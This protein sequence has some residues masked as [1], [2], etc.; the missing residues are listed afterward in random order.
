MQISPAAIFS[1][2][3]LR[4]KANWQIAC[5]NITDIVKKEYRIDENDN[6]YK[7]HLKT[8]FCQVTSANG[9]NIVQMEQ[10]WKSATI[11]Y[12]TN[13]SEP[14]SQSKAY[15][16][17]FELPKTNNGVTEIRF[18]LFQGTEKISNTQEKSI[19]LNDALGKKYK[20]LL[21]TAQKNSNSETALTNGKLGSIENNQEW[22][23]FKNGDMEMVIDFEK[24]RNFRQINV[25]FTERQQEKVFLPEYVLISASID[26]KN[27]LD[28]NRYDFLPLPK[29]SANIIQTA[30][31]PYSEYTSPKRFLK[32]TAKISQKNTFMWADEVTVR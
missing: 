25:N 16:A 6:D 19:A 11:H 32:I 8:I 4:Q 20:L 18:A 9:K 31:L 1:P 17:P 27:W 30:E 7:E 13:G 23:V 15:T 10:V 2:I 14:T 3:P 26:G 29:G 21:P 5:G 12:T 22:V 24:P 28:I